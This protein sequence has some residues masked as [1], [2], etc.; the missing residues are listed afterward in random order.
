MSVKPVKKGSESM[1]EWLKKSSFFIVIGLFIVLFLFFTRDR[2]NPPKD[3]LTPLT[4][5]YESDAEEGGLSEEGVPEEI[6]VDIKG[7]ISQPGV[8]ELPPDARVKDVVEL[9]SGFTKDADETSINLAQ[10]VHDEMIII[11]PSE[12]EADSVG[13]ALGDSSNVE[14][15]KIRIN[16]ATQ[17]E[18]ES[19]SGIGPSKAEAIIQYREEHGMFQSVEDLLEISG[20]GEKTL[21]NFRE[22]IQIP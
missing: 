8:Y 12:T 16:Y 22:N 10:K 14:Q 21:E 11:V 1:I 6:I 7:E 4:A 9:A 17:E 5:N 15:D 2:D 19:L 18:I 3:D 13:G 20:I